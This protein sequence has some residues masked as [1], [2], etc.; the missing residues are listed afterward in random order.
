M[1]ET[2]PGHSTMLSGRSPSSTGILSNDLGVPD[3]LA[4]LLG[5]TATGASPRRFRGT[6]LAD[7]MVA[8]DPATRILSVS[9]K[10]R[11]A[12]LPIGRMRVPIY[13]Y[14]Q[15]RFT[16]SRYYADSLPPWLQGWNARAP[17]RALAGRSWSLSRPATEY[18]EADA[19][20][21][22]YGGTR[23]TFP[24]V[25]TTDTARIES[26]IIAHTLMDSLTLDVA[27]HA[28]RAGGL[29]RRNGA[30][31]PRSRSRPRMTSGIATG[32]RRARSTI[33][34]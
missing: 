24:H 29:G 2:A 1:T 11:G 20:S 30:D 14:S 28:F 33:T 23:N 22:E 12:I 7:W 17:V 3:R 31:L 4:P 15:G 27:W 6:T 25:L 8:R 9:R 19:R 34:C 21:F 26:E 5:S 16:T 10:D 32:R 13:W 18:A